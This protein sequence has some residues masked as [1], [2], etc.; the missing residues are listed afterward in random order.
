MAG[1]IPIGPG[2]VFYFNTKKRFTHGIGRDKYVDF[3]RTSKPIVFVPGEA[4][5]Y[6]DKIS[7]FRKTFNEEGFVI[8]ETWDDGFVLYYFG[9]NCVC[10]LNVLNVKNITDLFK[11]LDKRGIDKK[12]AVK[13]NRS[14][15]NDHI[16]LI[17]K[18]F[19]PG[20]PIEK[21]QL[22]KISISFLWISI[23]I[24]LVFKFIVYFFF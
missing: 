20:I 9:I 7:K 2:R 3:G 8:T 1:S 12:N 6:H 24:L 5:L 11:F 19:L 16:R 22:Q 14:Q 21:S 4:V 18:D 15:E 17:P 10:F 13:D 23:F